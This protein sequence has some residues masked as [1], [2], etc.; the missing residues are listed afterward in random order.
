MVGKVS[1]RLLGISAVIGGVLALAPALLSATSSKSFEARELATSAFGLV[2]SALAF[3]GRW[4]VA[5]LQMAD[6]GFGAD[7][8]L[9]I[10]IT[11]AVYYTG[12]WIIAQLWTL[13]T[14][15]RGRPTNYKAVYDPD[16][17]F[18]QPNPFRRSAA[19]VGPAVSQQ[20]RSLVRNTAVP[21]HG[22]AFRSARI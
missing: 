16:P 5:S 1:G 13:Q 18:E 20:Y 21:S 11:A 2:W 14:I 8:I 6:I 15:S 10:G 22:H 7:T 9:F 12:F 19:R 4:V 17:K 3:P